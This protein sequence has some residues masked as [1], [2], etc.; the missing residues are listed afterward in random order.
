M[1]NKKIKI[2]D[3]GF[4]STELPLKRLQ[5][6]DP[7][8]AKTNSIKNY[9]III[10]IKNLPKETIKKRVSPLFNN[11]KTGYFFH[12]KKL[13][14]RNCNLA[15]DVNGGEVYYKGK[16]PNSYLCLK[17]NKK[18]SSIIAT[19]EITK[20][21]AWE[22]NSRFTEN[23]SLEKLISNLFIV[24]S[25]LRD[26]IPMHSAAIRFNDQGFLF[27]GYPNTGKT[28]TSFSLYNN[29][30]RDS[31]Y[32]CEDICFIDFNDLTIF[33]CPY[34]SGKHKSTLSLFKPLTY[35]IGLTKKNKNNEINK[36]DTKDC[37][38]FI[39]KMNLYEFNWDQNII[40]KHLLMGDSFYNQSSV[41][42]RYMHGLKKISEKT[43]FYLLSGNN[44][45][46]WTSVIQKHIM[47]K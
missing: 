26:K 3:Y 18:K 32:I 24:L 42:N 10:N 27:M 13:Y 5:I 19:L 33:S 9:E 7:E 45:K 12:N 31:D 47:K 2:T 29:I 37:F 36:K 41:M 28:T 15:S 43:N 11:P 38:R 34:T 39:H 30:N 16:I 23:Q 44:A 21:Y 20:T 8:L 6:G 46:E 4:I 14:Y 40:I 35:I 1:G 25:I 17:I 22:S